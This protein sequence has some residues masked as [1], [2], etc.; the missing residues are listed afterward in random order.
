MSAY[1][2]GLEVDEHVLE[3]MHQEEARGHALAAGDGVADT[4]IYIHRP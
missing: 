1:L 3:L 4:H 2:D